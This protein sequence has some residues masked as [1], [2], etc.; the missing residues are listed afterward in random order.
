MPELI[1]KEKQA[2]SIA[3]LATI[4]FHAKG[5]MQLSEDDQ[6]HVTDKNL[7]FFFNHLSWISCSMGILLFQS[8]ESF[9]CLHIYKSLLL[10]FLSGRQPH[11]YTRI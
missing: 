1:K 9:F 2:T 8:W 7:V 11:L 6:L 5:L 4:T 10:T 3:P